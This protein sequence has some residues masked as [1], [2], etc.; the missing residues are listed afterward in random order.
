LA[1]AQ[2]ASTGHFV[3]LGEELMATAAD[4]APV[5]PVR[6][7]VAGAGYAALAV[8]LA[9]IGIAGLIRGDFADFWDEVPDG[10]PGRG[11]LYYVCACIALASGAGLLWRR[12]ALPAARLLLAWML[13][14]LL[15]FK[16]PLIVA[17]PGVEGPYQD[18]SETLVI[19]AA[20][21][22]L[23]AVPAGEWD[24][25]WLALVTGERGVRVARVIYALA[26][27]GF[28]LSHFVYLKLTAPLVPAWL[29]G[30][31]T[32]SYLTGGAYLAAAAGMLS[33]VLARPAAV[34]SA[35]QMAGFTFLV[36]PPIALQGH[37]RPSQWVEFVVS[38]ALTAGAWV[39]ADSYQGGSWLLL[40]R[41]PQS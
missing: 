28:G 6:T 16:V 8:T 9:V 18:A 37:M 31:V 10:L 4:A 22:V 5:V 36:W 2:A 14:W 13:L 17:A 12:T 19:I 35:V 7:R 27:I 20:A 15:A 40:R 33:G 30:P 34:L 41:R 26:M 11:A 25:R 38:W 3:G 1:L 39:V 21:W 32:W 23:Y 29:P 24:R